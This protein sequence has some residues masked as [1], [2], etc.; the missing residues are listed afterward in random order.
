MLPLLASYCPA[1][2]PRDGPRHFSFLSESGLIA[3]CGSAVPADSGQGQC[4]GHGVCIDGQYCECEPEWSGFSTD[5]S[6]LAC[7]T[8]TIV[9]EEGDPEE[10][11]CRG[12][13][14]CYNTVNATTC[15]NGDPASVSPEDVVGI[16]YVAYHVE[17]EEGI[18]T[19]A[20]C[21]CPFGYGQPSCDLI[22]R[23]KESETILGGSACRREA[24]PAALAV[25]LLA[26]ALLVLRL[27]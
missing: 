5:C 20:R 10:V 2:P 13:G 22:I 15:V 1:L 24:S 4:S 26:A 3:G 14:T 27:R 7:P 12:Q 18:I 19:L 23:Q 25:T 9:Q 8:T 21:D 17:C 6:Q 11:Y 16:D